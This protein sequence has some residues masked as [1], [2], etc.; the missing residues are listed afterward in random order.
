MHK[1]LEGGDVT[2]CRELMAELGVVLLIKGIPKVVNDA[3]VKALLDEPRGPNKFSL[4]FNSLLCVRR[5]GVCYVGIVGCWFMGD[6]IRCNVG[7]VVVFIDAQ[8][9]GK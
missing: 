6:S 9:V 8:D 2:V 7:E 5:G 3:F 4:F 1:D